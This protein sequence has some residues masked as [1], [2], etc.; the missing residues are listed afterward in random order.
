M[1]DLQALVSGVLAGSLLSTSD[2][3]AIAVDLKSDDEGN[4]LPEIE[5][6]GLNSGERVKITIEAVE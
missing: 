4:Y 2:F 5:V 1:K 3:L 6:Q